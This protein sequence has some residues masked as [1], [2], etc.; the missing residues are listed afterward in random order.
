MD[1]EGFVNGKYMELDVTDDMMQAG[2]ILGLDAV[3]T[4]DFKAEK[5][6]GVHVVWDGWHSHMAKTWS[7]FL[8]KEFVFRFDLLTVLITVGEK[9]LEYLVPAG[10]SIVALVPKSEDS[11]GFW[12]QKTGII[13]NNGNLTLHP[14]LIGDIDLVNI[15][16]LII[17]D[18]VEGIQPELIPFVEVYKKLDKVLSKVNLTLVTGP[19]VGL[20]FPTAVY[21]TK[22]KANTKETEYDYLYEDLTFDSSG[23]TDSIIGTCEIDIPEGETL[24]KVAVQYTNTVSTDVILGWFIGLYFL[25]FFGYTFRKHWD[26]FSELGVD[27]QSGDWDN[28]FVQNKVGETS[29]SDVEIIFVN[30]S[31]DNSGN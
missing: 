24:E 23:G 28:N 5:P 3:V 22:L 18:G 11:K 1:V 8:N 4:L 17:A 14:Q 26:V 10:R 25:K 6:S 9:I 19:I 16:K 12:D 2:M 20:D 21:I 30:S 13:G 27:M 29:D 31:E 7:E 15:L